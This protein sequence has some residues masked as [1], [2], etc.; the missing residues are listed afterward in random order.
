M[1]GVS[2]AV[3]I[4]GGV[5]TA[6]AALLFF[7][8]DRL[9]FLPE[10]PGRQIVVTPEAA[11]LPYEDVTLN[12]ADGQTL[13]GWLVPVEAP[14]ATV[15][16]CH[17]NAGNIS[18]RLDSLLVFH[19]LHL[20]TLIFD[21]RGYGRSTGQP[22]E[23]GTYRDAE[24]AWRY[25]TEDRHLS[26]EQIVLFGRS[27]GAAI[28]AELATH[29][30]PAALIIESAFT[31]VPDMAAR[32]YPYFPARWLARLHYSTLDYL[33]NVSCP[34]LVVHSR[35]DDI[36]PFSNGERLYAAAPEPKQFLVLHGDHNTGFLASRDTYVAGLDAFLHDALGEEDPPATG[37]SGPAQ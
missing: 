34:V 7:G 5:Y 1:G 13:D 27:L 3:L 18:D 22:S 36:I 10:I 37:D 12:T 24:A 14:R 31:S 32:Q 19:D 6:F 4:A 11:H 15:L 2:L 9:L 8:Q 25:L 35:E 23:A 29:H 33:R 20:T 17:G 26:P 16:F 21:Y 30:H 28:A